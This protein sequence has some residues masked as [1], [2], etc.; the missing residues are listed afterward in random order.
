MQL[1]H[2]ILAIDNIVIRQPMPL[3]KA[4][5]SGLRTYR[6]GAKEVPSHEPFTP[7]CIQLSDMPS[8]QAATL[9]PI[10]RDCRILPAHIQRQIVGQ[11]QARFPLNLSKLAHTTRFAKAAVPKCPT[12]QTSPSFADSGASVGWNRLQATK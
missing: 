7:C 10:E 11:R 6:D 3:G 1:L 5:L 9:P 8:D 2:R 12:E 4:G